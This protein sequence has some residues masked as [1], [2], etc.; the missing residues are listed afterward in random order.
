MKSV[1]ELI[2]P[3]TLKTLS[4]YESLGGGWSYILDYSWIYNNLLDIEN[5]QNVLDVGCGKSRFGNYISKTLN[6][7]VLGIDRRNLPNVKQVDDFLKFN[8]EIKFDAVIWASSL[9]HN[10]P[11]EMLQLFEHSMSLLEKGGIFLATIPIS[12][13][14]SWN[15][16][17]NHTNLSIKHTEDLFNIQNTIGSYDN[18]LSK[19]KDNPNGL[20]DKYERR[21][22][23]RNIDYIIG[24][25]RKINE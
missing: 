25:I 16:L 10:S 22:K 19:Y 20:L 6:T 23:T 8:S 5:L 4:N 15:K 18:I 24:G 13:A 11:K 12:H 14:Y 7:K 9:E 17:S 2:D 21:Y 3:T 1:I